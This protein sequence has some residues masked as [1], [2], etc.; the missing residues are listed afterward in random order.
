MSSQEKRLE[1]GVDILV[2]TPGRLIE[3]MEQNNVSLANLEFLVFDEADRMLDMGFIGA[4]RVILEDIR[5]KPQTMLFSAT[6][7]A[8]MNAL[9]ADILRK[10][11]RI[12]VTPE[13]STAS[14][15][16]HVVYPVDEDRQT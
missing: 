3:H 7:S 16:A 14:T 6:S 9:A 4:I 8:Q 5:T 15:V 11:Q 10:P 12:T 13:N 2:A 1:Q